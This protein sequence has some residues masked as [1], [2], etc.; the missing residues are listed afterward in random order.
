[1][2]C[3]SRTW[4]LTIYALLEEVQMRKLGLLGEIWSLWLQDL[5]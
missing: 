1:M 4:K 2:G 3:H 5:G